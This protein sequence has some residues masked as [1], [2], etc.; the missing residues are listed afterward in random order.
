MV[1]VIEDHKP[2][3][4]VTLKDSYGRAIRDLRNTQNYVAS[5]QHTSASIKMTIN[6]PGKYFVLMMN[7]YLPDQFANLASLGR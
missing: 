5:P 1:T 3:A 4:A 6:T 7:Y 2:R